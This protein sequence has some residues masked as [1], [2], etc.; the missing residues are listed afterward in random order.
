[1][2]ERRKSLFYVLDSTGKK[3]LGKHSTLAEAK[4]QLSAIEAAKKKRSK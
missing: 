3:V 2:I 1:M 4:A